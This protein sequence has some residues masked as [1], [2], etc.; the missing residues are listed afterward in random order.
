MRSRR[1]FLKALGGGLTFG[2]ASSLG[3]F[4][5]LAQGAPGPSDYKALVAVFLFGG[6]DGNNL[7]VPNDDAGYASYARARPAIALPRGA[8]LPI[9]PASGGR[10]FGLHPSMPGLQSLFAA[11]H[12]ALVANVG[13]LVRPLTRAQSQADG[14]PLPFNLLSHEDQQLQWQTAQLLRSPE[15]GWGALAA[16]RL[17]ALS[18]QARFPP[19]VTV[20]GANIFCESPEVRSAAVSADGSSAIAGIDP[21]DGSP[22]ALAMQQLL[23]LDNDLELVRAASATTR[24]AYTDAKVLAAAQASATPLATPFPDSDLGRQLQQVARVI[25]VREALGL[26]RQ[27]FFVAL[28]GFDT[29]SDQLAQQR[30]L[31]AT[32]DGALDA[33]YRATTEL[34][35][36]GQVTSFTL[37]DFGRTFAANANGG[38]DHA[39]GNHHLMVGGAVR[40]GEL[41]GTFP[42]LEVGGPDDGSDEGRW[43]PT[44]ALDQY[45]A[46]LASWFGV[47]SADLPGLFPNLSQFGGTLP[48]LG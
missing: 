6:N 41:Y 4:E 16:E 44:T 12:A 40:G 18:P 15:S 22:L 35:V 26:R 11:R 8:L 37:S 39:W 17:Q 45:G 36:E 28:D 38:T 29:H 31:F 43:I 27:V 33:F 21:N 19:V 34:G 20:A 46:T 25:Q 3:R 23:S 5:A 47:K 42:T 14:A 2:L 32:L 10:A 7:L 1:D 9:Q 48:I 13:T 24:T 30:I